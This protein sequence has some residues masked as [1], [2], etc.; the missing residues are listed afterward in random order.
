MHNKLTTLA[1]P[2]DSVEEAPDQGDDDGGSHR[3]HLRQ[4]VRKHLARWQQPANASDEELATWITPFD[5]PPR[6]SS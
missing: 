3:D 4:R 1:S 6:P 5:L 2:V